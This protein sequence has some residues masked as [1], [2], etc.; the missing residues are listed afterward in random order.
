MYDYVRDSRATEGHIGVE[1]ISSGTNPV[2]SKGTPQ[3]SFLLPT[4]FNPAMRKLPPLLERIR[5]IKHTFYAIDLMIWTTSRLDC[6]K[7]D[8]L[9]EVTETMQNNLE[10]GNLQCA[11]DK[12]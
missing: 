9:Q 3:G 1:S 7:Q 8:F 2:P 12:P 4:L 10:A 6:E 11:P 5:Q